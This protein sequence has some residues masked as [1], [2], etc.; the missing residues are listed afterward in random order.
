MSC[1]R[2]KQPWVKREPFRAYSLSGRKKMNNM[3]EEPLNLEL[4]K[5]LGSGMVGWK[6]GVGEGFGTQ[7]QP[8]T[9]P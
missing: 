6:T 5:S 8:K 4:R 9:G 1:K 3:E 7:S 2:I